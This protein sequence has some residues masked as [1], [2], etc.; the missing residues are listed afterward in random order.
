[1]TDKRDAYVQKLKG[2]LDEWNAD[3]AKL[4]AKAEQAKA[5]SK[6]QYQRQI[7]NLK[8]QH[9]EVERK[10]EELSRAG[11]NA[12]GDLKAG[13]EIAWQGLG[14]AVKSAASRFS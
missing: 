8:A 7:E 6:V 4:E 9:V 10:I 14:E 11:D 2:K 1:V 13:V 5:D 12:W 3:I